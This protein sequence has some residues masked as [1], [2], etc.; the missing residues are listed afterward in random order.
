MVGFLTWISAKLAGSIKDRMRLLWIE[1]LPASNHPATPKSPPVTSILQSVFFVGVILYLLFYPLFG[2]VSGLGWL[3]LPDSANDILLAY[4][5]EP[6]RAVL[7]AFL[8]FYFLPGLWVRKLRNWLVYQSAL[9]GFKYYLAPAVS[10]V[11]LLYL[12]VALGSHYQ[13]NMR[14]SLGSFCAERQDLNLDN[15]G[16]K[17]GGGKAELVFDTSPDAANTPNNL[18]VSTGVYLK[19]GNRYRVSFKRLPEEENVAATGKWSFFGEES[20]MG[21]Q[22]VSHLSPVKS[23]VM[24]LL[25][26]LRR[27]F[28]RPW[29][30]IILRI[31]DR[32]NEEDFLDRPPP[33][34]TDDLL[35]NE[36]EAAVSEKSES[37]AEGLTPKRDGELF[38]YLNKPVLGW[39]GYESLVS[40]WIGSTGKAKVTVEK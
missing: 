32:G 23:V 11:G 28:D 34:Q 17:R 31:G 4:T 18:C 5:A 38:I 3:T 21:G 20:Y 35:A 6:V 29:G 7:A 14:D 36:A 24:A 27:T 40:D 37:L 25:F 22:P 19:T 16:F 12:A 2:K 13:F 30:S 1:Y 8:V 39:W 33:K 15:D 26:P 9:H 10:A